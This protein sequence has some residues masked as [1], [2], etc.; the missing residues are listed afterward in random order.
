MLAHSQKYTGF[1]LPKPPHIPRMCE[2]MM[3]GKQTMQVRNFFLPKVR[4]FQ[5]L[6]STS[7]GSDGMQSATT[8]SLSSDS[9]PA[10]T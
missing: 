4:P 7:I 10:A 8:S 5:R 9:H 6:P 1:F 3:N 2:Q